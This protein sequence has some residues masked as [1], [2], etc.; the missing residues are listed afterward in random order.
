MISRKISDDFVR[1]WGK[2]ITQQVFPF[3]RGDHS[4]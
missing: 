4:L 3:R 2:G 1:F